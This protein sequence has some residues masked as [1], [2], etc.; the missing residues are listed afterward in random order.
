M[1]IKSNPIALLPILVFLILYLG[2]GLVFEYVLGISM[3][4]YNIPV[5]GAFLVAII[6]AC[7]QNRKLSLDKKIGIMAKGVG[8]KNIMMMLLIFLLA[9][10]FTGTVGQS[11][12]AAVSYFMLDIIP[13]EF[14][15]AV[16]FVVACFISMAMGTSCGTIAVLTPIAV[17]ISAISGLSL[18]FC[19]ATVIGGAMFGD[20]LSFISDTT[21]ASTTGQ[22][23]LMKDKFKTNFWIA[24]PA[25][26]VA[27][28]IIL[29]ISLTGTYQPLVIPEYNLV[30][31]IPYLIVLVCAIIGINVFIVLLLGIISGIITV[32]AT[33]ANT[34]VDLVSGV[35][36]GIS[37]MFE[38][39]MVAILVAAMSALIIQHGGFEAIKNGIKKV[40]KGK[41][42]SK[43]G[44]GFLVG[45]MDIA[46][47]NNTVAIILANPIAKDIAEENGISPKKTASLLDTVSCVFQGI[48]PYGAQMLMALSA[49]ITA[50]YMIS[51]FDVIP[52]MYYPFLLLISVLVFIFVI[53]KIRDRK[54]KTEK[55]SE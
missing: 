37:G 55:K 25:A 8:D 44:I 36:A 26:I 11:S 38:V 12:A 49:V 34:F 13:V 32:L 47:A 20:N 27:L 19:V 46:T 24:L 2:L 21:V 53:D 9:G 10:V 40:F 54:N 22:G 42:G 51:A 15:A 35:G 41:A 16:I 4:F 43:L 7:C 48:L 31:I 18:P 52:Y 28:I 5:V 14:A 6:V 29:I 39:S 1:E 30:L 17:N 33:G 50:G 3:G 45:A 23:C